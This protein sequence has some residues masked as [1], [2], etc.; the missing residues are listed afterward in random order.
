M[1]KIRNL[2]RKEIQMHH[3]SYVR[4]NL[5]DKLFS[6]QAYE[7]NIPVLAQIL[8]RFNNYEYPQTGLWA[9]GKEVNLREIIPVIPLHS[10]IKLP[11]GFRPQ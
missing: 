7:G 3:M 1:A 9:H 10:F 11:A 4:C 6:S 5:K 8:D 2:S